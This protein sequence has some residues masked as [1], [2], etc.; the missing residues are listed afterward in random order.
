ME[1]AIVVG[2][3]IR[4]VGWNPEYRLNTIH[5]LRLNLMYFNLGIL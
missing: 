5:N 2:S 4:R 3:Y 1:S